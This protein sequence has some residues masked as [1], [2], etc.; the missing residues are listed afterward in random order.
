MTM[1][2]E[3]KMTQSTRMVMTQE[4]RQSIALLQLPVHE[5][6]DC[7]QEELA[8]NPLLEISEEVKNMA[9][10]RLASGEED[11]DP[12]EE[13]RESE[14]FFEEDE[15]PSS[16]LPMEPRYERNTGFLENC[17]SREKNLYDYLSLQL[18]ISAISE[19]KQLVGEYLIGNLNANG[20]LQGEPHEHARH[21]GIS[22]EEIREMLTLIQTFDPPGVGACS[23][24]ECLLIQLRQ[25]SC[26]PPAVEKVVTRYLPEVAAGKYRLVARKLGI[27]M[28]ELQEALTLIRR[29]NPKPGACFGDGTDVGY[30]MPDIIVE[31]IDGQYLVSSGDRIPQLVVNSFYRSMLRQSRDENVRGFIKKNLEGALWFIKSIEHRKKVIHQVAVEIVRVQEPF[32]E[33]GLHHL[34]PLTLKTVAAAIGVHES[35]V[36]RATTNKYMQTPRGLYPMKF[37]FPGSVGGEAG[38]LFASA[39]IKQKLRELIEGENRSVPLSD[40]QLAERL[41]E[42]GIKISRRTVAKY[43]EELE[44]PASFMR[45]SF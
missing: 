24:E 15:Y 21:L 6:L 18:K 14:S 29:L 17:L 42:E 30:I 35:T 5:L 23:L 27:S 34:K 9:A 32:L 19:R 1:N 7:I 3:L 37:F 31:K 39:G 41:R 33:K 12:T 13:H 26:Y 28:Q 22:P 4:L 2:F 16:Y 40:H 38:T 43:R 8:A 11:P 36:S 20:Y 44:I 45:R 25:F 10:D